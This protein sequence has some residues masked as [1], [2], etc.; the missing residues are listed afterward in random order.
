MT[1]TAKKK[2]ESSRVQVY[3]DPITLKRLDAIV[4]RVPDVE[5]RSGAIRYASRVATERLESVGRFTTKND[6][7]QDGGT[8]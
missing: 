3:L 4:K 7:L 5:S 1:K 6:Q 2:K 8:P